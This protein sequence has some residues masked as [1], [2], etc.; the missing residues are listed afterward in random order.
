MHGAG[1]HSAAWLLLLPS[2]RSHVQLEQAVVAVV[3]RLEAVVGHA[4]QEAGKDAAGGRVEGRNTS[5]TCD[6][7]SSAGTKLHKQN[8]WAGETFVQLA[9]RSAHKSPPC[10]VLTCPSWPSRQP[11]LRA[12]PAAA[13]PPQAPASAG[14]AAGGS[15]CCRSHCAAAAARRSTGAPTG[16]RGSRC[17]SRRVG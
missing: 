5:G 4:A 11:L 3:V 12:R 14:R 16:Q 15:R 1:C 17:G 7:F 6:A 9:V 8:T 2:P 10:P 13:H